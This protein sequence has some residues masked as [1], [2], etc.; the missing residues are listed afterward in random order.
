MAGLEYGT[1][2]LAVLIPATLVACWIDY[3]ARKV[4][5]W[6]NAAL[7]AS[8][9]VAQTAYFGWSGLGAATLGMLV[10]LGVLIIP[11]A[12]HGMGAGDVKLMAAIGAW[13]GPA[14]CFT[15]FAVGAVV[16]G[17]I[18]VAMITLARKWQFAGANLALIMAK[19][20][21]KDTAFSEFASARSFGPTSALLPY[22]IPL[23]IGTWLVLWAHAAGWGGIS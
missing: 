10:G 2:T 15:S 11:W 4:P 6:L 18:A 5:N 23:S 7:A 14:T 13:V 12:M 21:R 9:I 17:I 1:L 3:S 22:G 19:V 8:G 16:G 20:S